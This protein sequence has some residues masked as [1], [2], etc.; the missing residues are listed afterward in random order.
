MV[1]QSSAASENRPRLALSS[2]KTARCGM[3][4]WQ[5]WYVALAC[6]REE[7]QRQ[8]LAEGEGILY[9]IQVSSE[10]SFENLRVVKQAENNMY[11]C[12]YGPE[13]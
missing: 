1:V 7:G 5:Y 4:G 10:D 2:A 3:A 12:I 8:D 11:V 9:H 6:V 13:S